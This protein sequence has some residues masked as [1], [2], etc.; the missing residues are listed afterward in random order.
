MGDSISDGQLGKWRKQVGDFVK[1][2]EI[3]V[4]IETDK[5]EQYVLLIALAY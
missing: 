5:A 4:S 1:V 2:D 3:V